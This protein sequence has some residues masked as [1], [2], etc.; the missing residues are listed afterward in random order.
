E[1]AL[2][3]RGEVLVDGLLEPFAGDGRVEHDARRGG[4]GDRLGRLRGGPRGIDGLEAGAGGEQGGGAEERGDLDNAHGELLAILYRD[5]VP[6]RGGRGEV[7]YLGVERPPRARL[8]VVPGDERLLRADD[9]PVGPVERD[10]RPD[11]FCLERALV[12]DLPV[13][14]VRGVALLRGEL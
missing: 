5:R 1:R 9:L 8:E 4:I 7:V 6:R 12:R 3:G 13:E 14:L 2:A 10:Q 11:R